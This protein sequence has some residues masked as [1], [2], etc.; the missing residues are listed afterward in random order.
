MKKKRLPSLTS[1]PHNLNTVA[2]PFRIPII[3]IPSPTPF[4]FTTQPNP[5]PIHLS[6]VVL[7]L[8]SHRANPWPLANSSL[9]LSLRLAKGVLTPKS[10]GMCLVFTAF[11]SSGTSIHSLGYGKTLGDGYVDVCTTILY[12]LDC[13][14]VW[15]MDAKVPKNTFN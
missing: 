1:N 12:D 15:E 5:R 9:H 6:I 10:D 8:L 13:K 4:R 11:L 3:S 7:L 2:D 14:G